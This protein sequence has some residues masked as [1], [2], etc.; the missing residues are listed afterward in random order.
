M[1]L[2]LLRNPLHFHAF[3]LSLLPSFN[4]PLLGEMH[5]VDFGL[6]PFVFSPRHSYFFEL[7]FFTDESSLLPIDIWVEL[8]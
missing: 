8:L 7:D 3:L 5:F 4:G 1:S 2:I 6:L